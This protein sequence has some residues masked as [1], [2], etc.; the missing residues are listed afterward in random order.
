MAPVGVSGLPKG[1][2]AD[3]G[4]SLDESVPGTKT[5]AK[6][7]G[8]IREFDKAEEGS[9]YKKDGPDD[10]AKPQAQPEGDRREKEWST[11]FT[12]PGPREDDGSMTRYPYRDG[13]PNAHNASETA[14]IV[15]GM[16]LLQTAPMFRIA[17]NIRTA[18]TLAQIMRGLNPKTIERSSKCKVTLKRADIPNMNWIFSVDAGH[19]PKMVKMKATRKSQ[20]LTAFGKMDV[21]FSCSCSAWRWLGSEYHAKGEKFLNGKPVG[22]AS[23]P[24]VKDP[25]RINKVC[26]HVAAVAAL[27]EPWKIP[28]GKPGKA[29]PSKAEPVETKPKPS[30]SKAKPKAKSRTK[31]ADYEME[32]RIVCRHMT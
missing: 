15:L 7:V 8:D 30:K 28:A 10:V 26:K 21:S 3:H 19:G 17:L 18:T 13:I 5:F 23:T 32:M 29:K 14:H 16:W 2:P 6:P 12:S 1:S 31:K 24:D 27:V 9:I 11:S 25:K 20:N 22:T 4:R